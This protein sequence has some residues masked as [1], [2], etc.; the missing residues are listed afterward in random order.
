MINKKNYF[1]NN[2]SHEFYNKISLCYLYYCYKL[3]L[4]FLFLY[5]LY[6][7]TVSLF[8]IYYNKNNNK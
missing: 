2:L 6:N 8:T 4:T 7:L 5:R 3:S 1:N